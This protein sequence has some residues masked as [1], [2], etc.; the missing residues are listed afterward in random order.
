MI[1][2]VA[3]AWLYVGLTVALVSWRTGLLPAGRRA[4]L[5]RLSVVIPACNEADTLAPALASLLASDYPDLEIVLVNDRSSDATGDLMEA[6]AAHDP[7]VQV[8]HLHSLPPGWL[9]KN[10]AMHQGARRAS[11]RWILFSDADVVFQPDTLARAVGLAEDRGVEHLVLSPRVIAG[12]FWEKVFLS[13]FG[14]AFC[15]RFRPDRV[16]HRG[17][18]FAGIGAFNLVQREPYLQLGGHSTLALQVLDDMELGRLFKLHGYRQHFAGGGASVQVRWA[19][20]L[21]GLVMGLE[22]NAFAGV[23]YSLLLGLSGSLASLLASLVPLL[24]LAPQADPWLRLVCWAGIAISAI[25]V[26]P[27]TGTP[28]WA[29]A[30]FPLAGALFSFIFLRSIFLA[31][32]RGGIYWRGQFYP[33]SRL[34]E[35]QRALRTPAG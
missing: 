21:R 2:L 13:Y 32:Y 9:G 1:A 18:Y 28:R 26:S 10:H 35:A 4:H 8:V 7:R 11:G 29:G 17:R 5:P 22:K 30:C 23:N 25:A 12:T 34:K 14:T 27:G 16:G 6:M 3:W 24:L 20:G 15:F 33:L 31:Q 19:V